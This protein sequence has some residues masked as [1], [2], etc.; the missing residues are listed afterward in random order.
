MIDGI[1][2]LLQDCIENTNNERSFLKSFGQ[3]GSLESDEFGQ[4]FRQLLEFA[5]RNAESD[6]CRPMTLLMG[7][8]PDSM[9]DAASPSDLSDLVALYHLSPAD[10]PLR[11]Q[12]LAMLAIRG[13]IE[14]WVELICQEPPTNAESIPV[15][16]APL[17]VDHG[18]VVSADQMKC[19]IET[20]TSQP[21]VAAPIYELAN[22][23]F[24]EQKID[25]HPASDR[26]PQIC[27]LT[28]DLIQRL[29]IIEEGNLPAGSSP[30]SVAHLVQESVALIIAGMD[31]MG[32]LEYEPAIAKMSQASELKHRRIQVEA[33]AG[34]A[35]L[36]DPNG[37]QKLIEL[38]QH[39]VVRPRV[40]AY[41]KELGI[42]NEISLEHRGTIASAESELALWLSM[43]EQMGLAPTD[44]KLV[45]QRE[46]YWP[47]YENP[48]DCFLFEFA[49]GSGEN[50]FRNVGI[51]GPLT[52]AFAADLQHLSRG[53]QFAAFAGWQTVS[54]EIF[55]VPIERAERVLGP[56]VEKL[57][58]RIVETE[59]TEVELKMLA[60][61]FG[62]YVLVADGIRSECGGTQ[63]VSETDGEWIEHGIG[64]APLDWQIAL[65]IW[66]GRRLLASFNPSFRN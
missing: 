57:K 65:D 36:Q 10:Q 56:V 6:W 14:T 11:C 24:R 45:E 39:P 20:G 9:A 32:L 17:V 54:A 63:F 44:M 62:E 30:E 23:F 15:A 60:S 48:V 2:R 35:R 1:I 18:P 53:D 26:L 19:L 5:K 21:T 64:S 50:A 49:Y 12:L 47:S 28:G 40:I 33:A 29:E 22:R 52:H 7:A 13:D 46:L 58:R 51:S 4:L 59:T 8:L 27:Q 55:N 37:K 43:P 34:L 16:F 31:T 25:H 61:F 41:A 42:D 66:K 38:A 3:L